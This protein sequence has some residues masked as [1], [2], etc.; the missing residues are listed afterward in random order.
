MATDLPMYH[1]PLVDHIAFGHTTWQ[2]ELVSLGNDPLDRHFLRMNVTDSGSFNDRLSANKHSFATVSV[3]SEHTG[4]RLDQV[5]LGPSAHEFRKP[6]K[7]F[8]IFLN[9][10]PLE[11]IPLLKFESRW[12]I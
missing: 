10:T 1:S 5:L 9:I 2:T 11:A 7:Q 8:P 12:L 6:K 3:R 4:I